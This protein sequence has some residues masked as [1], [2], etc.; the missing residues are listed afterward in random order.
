VKVGLLWFDDDPGRRLEDKVLRAAQHYERKYGH[1]PTL[2]LVHRAAVGNGGRP[3]KAGAVE[4]RVGRSVLP[5][6]FWIGV[7]EDDKGR[8]Q[9]RGLLARVE[10]A[11]GKMT[12]EQAR[13]L[14]MELEG[15]RDG[16][17]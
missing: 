10:E 9:P 7:A 11:S 12:P 6:H 1:T 2:C 17:D 16:D 15:A 5:H 14:V 4:I 13:Q 8:S 3:R